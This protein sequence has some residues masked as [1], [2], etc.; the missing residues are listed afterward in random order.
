MKKIKKLSIIL[1]VLLLGV[2]VMSS[3][4]DAKKKKTKY[5]DLSKYVTVK[6][7]YGGSWGPDGY[8]AKI[9]KYKKNSKFK[10][11]GKKVSSKNFMKM[12]KTDYIFNKCAE[13]SHKYYTISGKYID[14]Q[15]PAK[16]G[17]YIYRVTFNCKGKKYVINCQT[18]H[19]GRYIPHFDFGAKP[20]PIV[21]YR[22][23]PQTLSGMIADCRSLV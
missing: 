6:V 20:S 22:H 8:I 17:K 23:L 13:V 2:I 21:P 4:A 7:E 9:T 10:Y 11:N 14:I 3:N 1:G 15:L 12:L 5:I 18:A 19:C 16:T